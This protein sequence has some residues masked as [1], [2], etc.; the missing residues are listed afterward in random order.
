MLRWGIALSLTDIRERGI[1]LHCWQ[2]RFLCSRNNFNKWPI[3]RHWSLKIRSLANILS[4][5][6]TLLLQKAP[7]FPKLIFNQRQAVWTRTDNAPP[8]ARRRA[9]NSCIR[10]PPLHNNQPCFLA[11]LCSPSASVRLEGLSAGF[12]DQPMGLRF[13][14]RDS[15]GSAPVIW[16]RGKWTAH[17]VTEKAFTNPAKSSGARLALQNCPQLKQGAGFF[18]ICIESSW[19]GMLPERGH[20]LGLRE[21][22]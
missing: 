1:W 20:D 7:L 2:C 18:Y 8:S 12:S 19:V 14:G 10:L 21:W 11:P 5:D 15:L 13:K 17:P 16:Q 22:G 4:I 6:S 9:E 3:E